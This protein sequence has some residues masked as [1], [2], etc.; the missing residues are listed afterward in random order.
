MAQHQIRRYNILCSNIQHGETIF[1]SCSSQKPEEAVA[2]T[3]HKAAADIDDD[4]DVF[5]V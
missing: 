2:A 3:Q 1:L 5:G 4:D